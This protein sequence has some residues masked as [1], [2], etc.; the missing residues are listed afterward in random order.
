M[1]EQ[2]GKGRTEEPQVKKRKNYRYLTI[3]TDKEK[4]AVPLSKSLSKSKNESID[5]LRIHKIRS[6]TSLNQRHEEVGKGQ[7]GT[8]ETLKPRKPHRYETTDSDKDLVSLE[9]KRLVRS[10][11][12]ERSS[13]K[14]RV[15]L[16]RPSPNKNRKAVMREAFGKLQVSIRQIEEDTWK[17]EMQMNPVE[18]Q[19]AQLKLKNMEGAGRVLE[20][21]V[22]RK[23]RRAVRDGWVALRH[24]LQ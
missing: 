8:H 21:L 23:R 22:R 20:L 19:L 11:M 10:I 7:K 3:E 4:A 2:P 5:S 6:I 18:H 13:N 15:Q 12:E 24:L 14:Q 16:K 1:K 9:R 17:H